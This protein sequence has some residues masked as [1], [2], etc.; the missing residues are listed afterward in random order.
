[1]NYTEFKNDVLNEKNNFL[2]YFKSDIILNK[3]QYY[4]RSS[5]IDN[6]QQ[7]FM[8]TAK[9]HNDEFKIEYPVQYNNYVTFYVNLKTI[10]LY[11]Q[12]NSETNFQLSTV[13]DNDVI[14]FMEILKIIYINILKIN[15]KNIFNKIPKENMLSLSDVKD[16]IC[17][18]KEN[19]L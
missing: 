10:N 9:L 17:A 6:S 11:M 16:I 13:L 12:N 15:P 19:K 5:K 7:F 3:L 2:L 1:M 4:F 18:A 8:Y 14:Q